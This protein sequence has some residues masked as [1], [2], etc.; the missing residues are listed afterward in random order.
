MATPIAL[1]RGGFPS[2][3]LCFC[4]QIP[5]RRASDGKAASHFRLTRLRGYALICLALPP[6]WRAIPR[7]L[8]PF[9]GDIPIRS[10]PRPD[11]RLLVCDTRYR[12]KE[13]DLALP[14][15]SMR[16]LLEAGAHFG[17]Q[18]HRWNPK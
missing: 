3:P 12:K 5:C 7:R 9:G 13:T 10:V 2:R 4:R 8:G 11:P 17:H 16:S 6:T 14:E 18:T 1:G 15:F